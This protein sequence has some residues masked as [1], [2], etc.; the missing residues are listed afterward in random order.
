[1]PC[2]LPP[3]HNRPVPCP[4]A[5]TPGVH[6]HHRV[7]H[8]LSP[9]ELKQLH[10]RKRLAAFVPPTPR[11]MLEEAEPPVAKAVP[12]QVA[13]DGDAVSV[14]AIARERWL[15][16]SGGGATPV[17]A[18]YVWG[19]LVRIDVVAAP[20]S[21]ALAF[22]G[23]GNMRVY[24][25]PLLKA[26][27]QFVLAGEEDEEEGEE[28]A[29]GAGRGAASAS[30][31]GGRGGELVCSASVAARGGLVPHDLL[32]KPMTEGGGVGVGGRSG[33]LADIAISGGWR[34]FRRGN[35]NGAVLYT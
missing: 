20:S 26:D 23:S 5:D 10:P 3:F 9:D 30:S 21:T 34:R 6:L 25:M 27:Q 14:K 4:L 35:C 12:E 1:M 15:K 24:S 33:A 32:I 2:P 16:K 8:M 7:P 29:S 18:T 22:M 13:A 28:A 11:E 19:G 31:S 17:S